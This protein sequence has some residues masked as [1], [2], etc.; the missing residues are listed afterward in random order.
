M[1]TIDAMAKDFAPRMV[2]PGKR[3]SRKVMMKYINTLLPIE[4]KNSAMFR[5]VTKSIEPLRNCITRVASNLV[6]WDEYTAED[7]YRIRFRFNCRVIVILI[8]TRLHKRK[9][10]DCYA[11]DSFFLFN[12]LPDVQVA[13]GSGCVIAF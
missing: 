12:P 1:N 3:V 7:A 2:L 10:N 11:F 5:G 13:G 6:G 4:E 8:C 9:Q